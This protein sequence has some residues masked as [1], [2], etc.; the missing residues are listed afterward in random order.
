MKTHFFILALTLAITASLFAGD[1]KSQ[2]GGSLKV[3]LFGGTSSPSGSYKDGISSARNGS[4]FG[5]S[6]DYMFP[7][8]KLGIGID[9]R[10]TGHPHQKP[11]TVTK[12]EG[13]NTSTT[14]NNYSSPLRF[15]HLGITLGP[16]Y[17]IG[18]G[19]LAIDLYAKGGMLFEQFPTYVRKETVVIDDPFSHFPPVAFVF[20][21]SVAKSERASTWTA[22][23]GAKISFEVLPKVE[24]FLFGDYQ[25]A[26]G[27]KG[28][29]VVEDLQNG[30]PP[31]KIPVKM[32]S[33]GGGLRLSF[34]DGRDESSLSRSY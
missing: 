19:R 16:V 31:K 12:K 9:A 26:L 4:T 17:R 28:Q 20:D 14:V 15:R 23:M 13:Y 21:R 1:A 33:L 7:G 6:A 11:D 34:G 2:E 18:E 25:T 24:I 22:L 32:V 29:F 10:L 8:S 30:Q 3:G 27:N 5:L